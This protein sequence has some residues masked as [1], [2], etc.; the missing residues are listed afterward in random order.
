M[1][2]LH[3]LLMVVDN[4]LDVVFDLGFGE[5]VGVLFLEGHGSGELMWELELEWNGVVAWLQG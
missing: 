5:G 1:L 3:L 2:H 4:G